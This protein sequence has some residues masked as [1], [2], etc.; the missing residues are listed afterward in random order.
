MGHGSFTFKA[1]DG[2]AVFVNRWLPEKDLK[3]VVQISHG[4]A[5]HS[6]RYGEF[7]A[8]LAGGG[9]AVYANDHRGH[10][11]TAGNK[12]N[13]GYFAD[14]NGWER[15]VDDMKAVTDIIKIEKSGLPVFLFGHSM[16]S[17][18]SRRY[19]QKYGKDVYGTILSGTGADQGWLSRI[20]IALAKLEIRRKGKKARSGLLN[21]LSFGSYNKSFKENRTDFDWLSRDEKAVDQ[22]IEDSYCGEV[23]T[24]GFFY[25][26]LS[27]IKHLDRQEEISKI[28]KNLP[29][30]LFSGDKD[31]V[32]KQT[33]DVL[34]TYRSLKNAGIKEVSYKF[35]KNGR[36]EMLNELNKDEVYEDVISWIDRHLN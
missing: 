25:D 34:K 14:E 9:F 27:G 31:P 29:I 2:A 1:N 4:M 7:A 18:L 36:H 33:K 3:G 13:L 21:R 19:I 11:K 10:G 30:Y 32:G 15:V 28:P 26:M 20:A 35:Y 16:G 23:A 5:E 17:Y 6:E 8:A 12:E 24:A 22:Y